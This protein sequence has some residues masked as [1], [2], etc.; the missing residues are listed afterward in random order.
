M[1][2]MMNFDRVTSKGGRIFHNRI[3]RPSSITTESTMA[4]SVL[5]T[6]SVHIP[7]FTL[8]DCLLSSNGSSCRTVPRTISK[9]LDHSFRPALTD[10]HS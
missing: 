8:Q 6:M 3:S 4:T 2:V 5:C 1:S 10:A 9:L 7:A